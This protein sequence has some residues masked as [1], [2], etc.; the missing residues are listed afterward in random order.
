MRIWPGRPYPLG[1]IWDGIGTNFA[2]YSENATQVELCLFDSP[3]AEKEAHRIPLPDPTDMVWQ[4]GTPDWVK[5]SQVQG[6]FSA[7]RGSAGIRADDNRRRPD[8]RGFEDDDFGRGPMRR[9]Q[10][11]SKGLLI[12]LIA[13]GSA[14]VIIAVVVIIVI[15]ANSGGDK[16]KDKD[17]ASGP[18]VADKDKFV[19]IKDFKDLAKDF[20]KDFPIPKAGPGPAGQPTEGGARGGPTLADAVLEAERKAIAAAID[21][22]PKDL[23]KVADELSVSPT[24]LWRKMKRLGFKTGSSA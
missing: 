20:G 14:L 11:S 16:K 4:E 5:A 19:V 15:V 18:P 22:Y 23:A 1:A 21:R 7:S 2:L 9:P 24:T 17:I 10:G 8:P 12:G 6:L 13:G 3:E